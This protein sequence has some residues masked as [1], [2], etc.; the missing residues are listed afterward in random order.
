[1]CGQVIFETENF[2]TAVAEV[3]LVGWRYC[4]EGLD[5]TFHRPGVGERCAVV[6]AHSAGGPGI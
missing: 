4:M 3:A 1:M 6:G 5:V 2:P